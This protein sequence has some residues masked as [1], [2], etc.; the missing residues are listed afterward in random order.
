[1]GLVN[2]TTSTI[3][4]VVWKEGADIKKD[5]LQ[6]LLV[7]VNQ[8]DGPA[9]FTSSNN[10]KVV[11]IFS[12]F[13]KW[14]GSKGTCLCHQFPIVL[15]FAFT[16]HKS[17]GLTLDQAV[18]D[19]SRKEHIAGLT[20]VGVLRVK[21]LSGLIFEWGFNKELFNPTASANKQA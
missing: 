5:L 2:G 1:M 9:L 11:P 3:E 8:Y 15:A 20:Y 18:L 16:I 19:I 4:D 6:V 21:K 12:T 13:Y 7:V 17:Q 10:R 14:E